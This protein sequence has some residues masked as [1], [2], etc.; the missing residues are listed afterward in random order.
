MSQPNTTK[1]V[2]VKNS[3]ASA[4]HFVAE[5]FQSTICEAVARNGSCSVALAGGTTPHA[6]YHLMA[7]EAAIAELPWGSVDFFF[8]DERDVPPDHVESNYGMAQR[9][10]LDN[11]PVDPARVHPMRADSDDMD[12]AAREYEQIIRRTVQQENNG[13]PSFDIILLGLG[14]DGHTASL[15]PGTE[16]LK[17]DKRLVVANHV[18]VHD[19]TRMTITYPLINAARNVIFLVTGRDKAEAVEKL[20][21]QRYDDDKTIPAA[22]VRPTDG[23]CVV[24]LDKAAAANTN[25]K[26]E[27]D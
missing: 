19:R 24:V 12:E 25:L 5:L 16:A 14:G 21:D 23:L 22:R 13:I 2:V 10:L 9:T 8:G 6:L 4:T 1:R 27:E 11:V 20:L 18:P 7:F 3:L 17:E 26:P 15:F